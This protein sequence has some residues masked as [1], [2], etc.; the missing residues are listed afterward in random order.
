MSDL[1]FYVKSRSGQLVPARFL[2]YNGQYIS[3]PNTLTA[4]SMPIYTSDGT[5]VQNANPNG[6]LIVP[7]DYTID[8][9]LSFANQVAAQLNGPGTPLAPGDVGADGSGNFM[10]AAGMMTGAFVPNGPQDLQRTYPQ[11]SGVNPDCFVSAF[12][13]AASFNLGVIS[14]YSGFGQESA[15]LGGGTL[16][17]LHKIVNW[18]ID[19]SGPDFNTP[20]NGRSIAAGAAFVDGTLGKKAQFPSSENSL[21]SSL[22]S[23]FHTALRP[24]DPLVLD[25]TGSGVR[26]VGINA[27]AHFDYNGTGFAQQTA[28]VTP[29][30][31][32]LVLD[33]NGDGNITGDELIGN[34]GTD[35]TTAAANGFTTLASLDSNGDGVIDSHD[36]GFANLRVWVDAN[37][38]GKSEAGELK[39]LT[40]LGITSISLAYTGENVTDANGNKHLAISSFT[41]A[42][43]K[44]HT[45][46]D[47]WLNVDTARTI[48][49]TQTSVNATIAALP[50]LAGFGNVPSL[51]A[52]M[53]LDTTGKLQGL[54]QSFVG[55]TDPTQRAQIVTDLIYTWAGV[56]QNNPNGR[57]NNIYGHVIDARKIETLESFL[58]QHYAANYGAGAD[59]NPRHTDAGILSNAFDELST[60]VTGQLLAQSELKDLCAGVQ[61]SLD[62]N[63]KAVL[64]VSA[65]VASLSGMYQKDPTATANVIV[66]LSSTLKSL[67]D[68]GQQVMTALRAQGSLAQ[69]GFSGQLAALGANVIVA[70]ASHLVIR[71]QAGVDNILM[72]TDKSTLYAGSGTDM[73]VAGTGAET[74]FGGAGRDTFVLKPGFGNVALNESS[75]VGGFNLDDVQ[76]GGGITAAQTIAYRDQSNNL[77]LV[78][79]GGSQLTVASYFSNAANQPVIVFADGTKWDYTAVASN[80]VLT[81]MGGGGHTLNGL[82]GTDNRIVGAAGDVIYAGDRND[83]I[84]VGKNNT[85]YAGRGTD[86]V[87]VNAGSGQVVFNDG[88]ASKTGG[89]NQDVVK[90]GTG[91][92]ASSTQIARDLSNNL[93]LNFGNGDSLKL[94]GYFGSGSNRPMI[95]FADGTNWDYTAITNNLVFTDTSAGGNT[96]NAL[97]GVDNRI[98]GAT[99]DTIYGADRN[100]T[101]TVG[102]NN[103]VYAGRGTDTILV[104]AGSGQV[105]LNDSYSNKNSG[106]NQDV[107]SLGAGI[108][109][110]NTQITRDLSNN[111]V[112]SFGNGDSLKLL[113]YFGSN[114]NR[115][116]IT[117][118]DGT[119]WDY[120]TI[121][122]NLVFTDTSAGSN[123]LN[124]LNGVDNR[125]VGATGDTIYG[126]DRNDTITVGK[127][128]TVNAGRG[129]DTIV[130][131]AGSGQTV[132]NDNYSNKSSGVNQDVVALGAG[133]SASSTQIT[134]DLSNNLVL[135]FGNGD[136]VKLV[137]YFGSNL[138]RP[139]IAFAD[140]TKWDYTA[141]TNNLVFMDTSAGNTTLYALNGVDNRI[142]GAMGDTIY[143]ADRNDTITVGKNNTVNAGRGTDTIIV[144]TGTGQTVLNDN[145]SNKSSGVNQDVVA[146]GAGISASNTQIVRDLSNNLV[147]G[148]GNG[149]SVKLVGYFGSNLNRPTI[150]FAD[151]TKWDYTTITN[152]LVFTDTSAGNTTLY[153]LNGVDNRI[154]GA[155]G[156]TIYGADR[157][158]TVTVGK[159]NT[160][161]AGRGTDTIIVGV[162]S[163]QTVL[164]DNY[165]NKSS[166]VNQDVV[167]LGVGI[168]AAGTQIVRDLSNDLVLNFGNGDSLKLTGY[169][170]SGSNRPTITFADGTKWDYSV[171]ANNLVFT[172]TSAGGNTLYGLNGV[173]NRI[174]GA[175]G[176]SIHGGDR[177]DT[178]TA[179]KN[180]TVYAGNGDDTITVGQNNTVYA[181]RGTDT[182]IVG[183]GSGQVVLNDNYSSKSISSNQDVVKLGAG[184]SASSTQI[185]RDLSN[186]LVLNFGNGDSLKLIGYFG[187]SSNR[188]TIAFA[189]GTTWDYT[190]VTNNLVFTDT[191]A[192]GNTLYALNGVDNRIVGATGDAIYAADHNDTITVGKNNTVYAGRGTDTVIVGAGSGQ[193]VLNDNYSSK[194]SSSTQDV[195]K[196]G[197]GIAASTTQLARDLSNNLVLSF[198]NGDSLKLTGYFGSTS[199]RPLITFADGTKWDYT[200][201]TNSL[202]FTDTTAGGNTLYALTGVDNRIVGATGDA[203]YA[204]DH[205]DTITVGK[206]N[207]VYA[208]RGTDTVIVGVGS[209]Q[210]VLN[211]NYSSKNNSSTQDVVKLGTGIAASTTQ[212]ARDLSNNLVLSFGN[213]DSLKLTGYFGST[214]NRPTITFAD[215]TKWDYTAVTNNLVF[216]DTT[217]GG[218]SLYA[219]NGVDNRIVGAVGDAIYAADHNDTITVGKNNT[220]Y[221][222]RGT[223]TIIVGVGSGQVVLNDNYST[224]SSGQNQD[225]VKLGAGISASNTQVARDL[226]NNLV[227]SFGNGDSLKLTGY[228][229]STSNRPAISFADGTKWDYTA[230]TNNLVFT[231]TSAGGNML[232]ALNGVDNRIVGAAGDSIRGGDHNDTITAGKNNTIYAGT[233]ADLFEASRGCGAVTINEATKA[234]SSNHD[235]LLLGGVDTNQLWFKMSGS[236]L[237]I[238]MMGTSDH[239]TINGWSTSAVTSLQTIEVDNG[240]GGKSLLG[241]GAVSQLVQ[242][243][244]TFSANNPG[245]DPTSTSTP[246]IT[247]PNVMLA[248]SSAWHR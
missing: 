106:A 19:T 145:Y 60:Y 217:A 98:V 70:D 30:E 36:A 85:V 46:E 86:T 123:T 165:S 186:N 17:F 211:D 176:D 192:G 201:I 125:I 128:N 116:T 174:V 126:A 53:A 220:V 103:T 92:S 96:L 115:P 25:L 39:T 148:F 8:G 232:Y 54:V 51:H 247:D 89:L 228:F 109:A 137:G 57:D 215:G 47:L 139:V 108:S 237:V 229:G 76:I 104:G 239:V 43:G 117:F 95:S 208:G 169:F 73:L 147:L 210:V 29:D 90:L 13:D 114:L 82:Y 142:V 231:D 99:G 75:K 11:S 107:V 157:N 203:I 187:S 182:V 158:D 206:N 241:A 5:A 135:S 10:A 83:T 94:S 9:A 167:A 202:V 38:D 143:G 154:A 230:V 177:N 197:T 150:A 6:Y 121:T 79:N 152:N 40:E 37:G 136:S 122:N 111:L 72:G 170:G 33:K 179:A 190:A 175:A 42:D 44:T 74:L 28:W 55:T 156:D 4:T 130:V 223:D 31:G 113:G 194:N 188:P 48:N 14:E 183:A 21:I 91:I 20:N 195:V 141:I 246:T 26:T 227:L 97:Y 172:D 65:M 124:A 185:A 140:G 62:A 132:L 224:K 27:G 166:G 243:M 164:N 67:G 144:G 163:G 35:A 234:N 207:T 242:A 22:Q 200:A 196:L 184:I 45:M 212:L 138:N 80:V 50:D 180:S 1:I 41:T 58:G 238:D 240:A 24:V 68:F 105:V 133:I 162:G 61:L 244:A 159:N 178:I 236:N 155:T 134:R 87:I 119:N 131:N 221:A 66:D 56:A 198:G 160:V 15:L 71:G 77:V 191:S 23:L 63:G 59:P 226:S 205:N 219:L 118:A 93:I 214:S 127:N 64:D 112:L 181:G 100:D 102:K 213:G 189:D 101:I 110:S 233:G 248:V 151:G 88:Y 7:A 18:K 193:V 173:D 149:D 245:F 69:S 209:G 204:A 120:T 129:T 32:I 16:N 218:N 168:S 81:D 222:G 225:V 49:T 199:N 161:N 84:T 146:L 78:F 2:T 52:A 171:V 34:A 235:T 3:D 153:A 216:T 12:T